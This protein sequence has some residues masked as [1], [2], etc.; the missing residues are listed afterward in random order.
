M[1]LGEFK[2]LHEDKGSNGRVFII[3]L[4]MHVVGSLHDGQAFDL[5]KKIARD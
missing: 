2:G 1:A 3:V 4:S 5:D